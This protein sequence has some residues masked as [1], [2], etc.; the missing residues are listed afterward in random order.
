LPPPSPLPPPPPP[1]PPTHLPTTNC[2][3][4]CYFLSGFLVLFLP[5]PPGT[6][7]DSMQHSRL[8]PFNFIPEIFPPPCYIGLSFCPIFWVTFFFFQHCRVSSFFFC[9]LVFL[10]VFGSMG[11]AT[12]AFSSPLWIR[13]SFLF[14][15]FWGV[16][17]I[18]TKAFSILCFFREL[19]NNIRIL[20]VSPLFF[21][22]L[23][24]CY[25]H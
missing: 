9:C 19:L 3:I 25:F 21:F 15:F 1:R 8:L 13:P 22:F 4:I 10:S 17:V 12:F 18:G 11:A 24:V 14:Y 7:A 16:S 2:S 20:R 6:P 23:R 5:A